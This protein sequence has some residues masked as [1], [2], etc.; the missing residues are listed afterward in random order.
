[1]RIWRP[2]T[3]PGGPYASAAELPSPYSRRTSC[4][5]CGAVLGH[6]DRPLRIYWSAGSDIIGDVVYVP[7]A[8]DIVVTE[9][10]MLF[11]TSFGGLA[12]YETEIVDN[13]RE[14]ASRHRPKVRM[15]Y[16]GP[17]LFEVRASRLVHFDEARTRVKPILN[18]CGHNAWRFSGE[19][20]VRVTYDATANA[21]NKVVVPREVGGGIYV[22]EPDLEGDGFFSLRGVA[23]PPAVPH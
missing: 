7:S 14:K 18:S 15:P 3:D 20:F 5:R 8:W 13:P 1:M 22:K 12:A 10:L 9:R 2:Y 6:E 21:L 11:L 19:S 23:R 4:P 16:A 17:A